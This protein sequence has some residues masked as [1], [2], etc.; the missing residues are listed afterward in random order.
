MIIYYFF[1]HTRTSGVSTDEGSGQ[2]RCHLRDSTNMKDDTH[3]AHTQSFQQGEYEMIIM[4]ARWYTGTFV[5]LKVSWHLAY[6]WGKP[7]KKPLTQETCPDRGSNPG[8]LRDRRACYRLFHSGGQ[9][10]NHS[11]LLVTYLV[12]H[13]ICWTYA[14]ISDVLSWRLAT[15]IKL[16]G[17]NLSLPACSSYGRG[18]PAF[19]SINIKI[20]KEQ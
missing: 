4:A 14:D 11:T 10:I 19:N 9:T 7:P 18:T 5:S 13:V 3:Q 17:L 15:V 6:G 1:N 12:S 8:P 20:Y 2:C 16:L